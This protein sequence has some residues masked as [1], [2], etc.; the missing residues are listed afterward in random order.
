MDGPDNAALRV[1]LRCRKC[2]TGYDADPLA[3]FRGEQMTC[4]ICGT[5]VLVGSKPEPMQDSLN[6]ETARRT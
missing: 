2:A 4:P 6:I 1:L 5:V 3:V